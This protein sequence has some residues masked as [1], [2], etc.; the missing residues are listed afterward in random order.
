M[1]AEGSAGF[2]L[3]SGPHELYAQA[4]WGLFHFHEIVLLHGFHE[5]SGVPTLL[6]RAISFARDL[7][8]FGPATPAA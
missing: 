8:Q 2:V 3:M 5:Q 6:E 4:G 7:G 1:V